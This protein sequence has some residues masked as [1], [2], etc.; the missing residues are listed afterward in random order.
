MENYRRVSNMKVVE[1]K[2]WLASRDV[3]TKGQKD[4]LIA[5]YDILT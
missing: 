2:N 3:L 5:S 4:G 1:L